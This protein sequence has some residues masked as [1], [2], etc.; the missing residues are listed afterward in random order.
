MKEMLNFYG[1]VSWKDEIPTFS[2]ESLMT[3]HLRTNPSPCTLAMPERRLM[4]TV[5]E[6]G[7]KDALY[8]K[9]RKKSEAL[10]W[11]N[12]DCSEGVHSFVNIC[13]VFGL[14]PSAVR[15]SMHRALAQA[16]RRRVHR[17]R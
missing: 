14:D 10:Q 4:L 7:F 13:S 15:S 17:V 1:P 6:H 12:D 11:L 16:K 9:G 3:E 2:V 5:M 8:A